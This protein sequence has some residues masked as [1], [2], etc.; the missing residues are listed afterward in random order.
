[1]SCLLIMGMSIYSQTSPSFGIGYY[2]ETLLHPG[3]IIQIEYD[4]PITPKISIPFR[5]DFGYYFHRNNHQAIFSD[6]VVGGRW[7]VWPRFYTGISGGI[8]LMSSWH[9]SDLGVFE[10]DNNNNVEKVS[11]YAG[12]DFMPSVNLEFGFKV[13]K[14]STVEYIWL[15]PKIFWQNKVNDKGL[16]HYAIELGYNIDLQKNKK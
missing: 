10:V 3:F 16:L 9:H 15:R 2:G 14:E 1:M 5:L 6:L 7:R 8:G 13:K 12:I 11:N 4:Q